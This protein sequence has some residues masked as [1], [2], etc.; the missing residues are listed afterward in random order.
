M[1]SLA[2]LKKK[3][4]QFMHAVYELT[5]GNELKSINM[6]KLGEKLGF[7]GH[8]S[9]LTLKIY[10]YLVGEGLIR[11][12]GLGGDFAITHWGIKE[13]ESSLENPEQPTEHFVPLA[14]INV[15]QVGSMVNS[16]IQ[17]G[18]AGSTQTATISSAQ[19]A[20]LKQIIEELRQV[21]ERKTLSPE[22]KEELNTE[23]EVL[24]L[25]A[26]SSKPKASRI[27]DSLS[28]AQKIL[29]V[30]SVGLT[31]VTKIGALLAGL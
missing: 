22:Q 7:G 19:I 5:G 21:I 28:T 16:N 26:K 23:I 8:G 10:Q 30:A 13:V 20:D 18:G 25:E 6:W 2:E 27:K 17:Q 3:R 11:G 31:V 1:E 4:T 14:T 29:T 15:I 12:T 9:E 24:A